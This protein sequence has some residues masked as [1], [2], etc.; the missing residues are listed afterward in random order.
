MELCVL[1]ML[2]RELKE[3]TIKHISMN[4]HEIE[5]RRAQISEYF[6]ERILKV[7][8]LDYRMDYFINRF[9]LDEGLRRIL[10]VALPRGNARHVIFTHTG[11]L[12]GLMITF[13]ALIVAI[14]TLLNK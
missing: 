13:M 7:W 4:S 6:N 8:E 14:L 10:K 3:F 9:R 11:S 1:S 2:S 5:L 12:I